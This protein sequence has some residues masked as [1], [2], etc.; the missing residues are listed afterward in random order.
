MANLNAK[1][2]N[3]LEFV[4]FQ[5]LEPYTRGAAGNNELPGCSTPRQ[6]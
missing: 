4:S 6:K 3:L 1:S 2:V 5:F